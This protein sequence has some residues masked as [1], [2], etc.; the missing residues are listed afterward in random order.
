MRVRTYSAICKNFIDDGFRPGQV[1]LEEVVLEGDVGEITICLS[2]LKP[3][4]I[5]VIFSAFAACD[6]VFE[7]D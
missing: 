6:N 1:F 5:A 3:C 7:K 4:A 2:G